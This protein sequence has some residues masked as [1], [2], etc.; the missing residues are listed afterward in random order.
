MVCQLAI[1]FLLLGIGQSR[2]GTAEESTTQQFR[3]AKNAGL[4]LKF[5]K[6]STELQLAPSAQLE[7]PE[8][9]IELW[10]KLER[11]QP[12]HAQF[13]RKLASW[14]K[15]GLTFAASQSGYNCVQFRWWD[16]SLQ[17]LPDSLLATWYYDH[18]HHFAAVY[19]RSYRALYIDGRK[20]AKLPNEPKTALQHDHSVPWRIGAEGLL[21]EIDELRLWSEALTEKTL[22]QNLYRTLKGNEKNLVGYWRFDEPDANDLSP[23]NY[24]W[25]DIS[26]LSDRLVESSAPLHTP[27]FVHEHRLRSRKIISGREEV[28]AVASKLPPLNATIYRFATSLANEPFGSGDC[29]NFVNHAMH[30]AGARGRDVYVFGESVSREDAIPGDLVQFEKFSSPSFSSNR[31]SAI[32]WR[33][34]G[35]GKI[36]VAHQNAPPHGMKVGLWEIDTNNGQGEVYFYRPTK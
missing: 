5:D 35:D 36:T 21:G 2:T 3:R 1:V 7:P 27:R 8:L 26:N 19:S 16:Q 13:I 6:Q 31:H 34:H 10:A 17:T 11:G 33:N 20:V 25:Q 30:L 28:E 23:S 22:Q 4:A 15:P 29:W 9:T 24:V 14:E 32:L 18:W 12:E